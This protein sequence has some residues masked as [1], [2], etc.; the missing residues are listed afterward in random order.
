[1]QG[2][3]R[4]S[5]RFRGEFHICGRL[6]LQH[7][8]YRKHR[9]CFYDN[10]DGIDYIIQIN[11]NSREFLAMYLIIVVRHCVQYFVRNTKQSNRLCTVIY[12]THYI[13][14]NTVSTTQNVLTMSPQCARFSQMIL[15][16]VA[17][18]SFLT[19]GESNR[20]APRD[21]NYEIEKS[22]NYLFYFRLFVSVF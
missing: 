11:D 8:M 22:H 16:A 12:H 10:L 7:K 9:T 1:M 4:I 6:R 21:R 14:T 3:S 18:L 15:L 19:P 17:Q 2:L 5:L 20:N 13:F